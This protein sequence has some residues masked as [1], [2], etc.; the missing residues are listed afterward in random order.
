MHA[1]EFREPGLQDIWLTSGWEVVET[2]LG[3]AIRYHSAS[4]LMDAIALALVRKPTRLSSGEFRW[5]RRHVEL[6]QSE[7]ATI[8]DRDS[9]TVS[10]IERGRLPDALVDREL[11]RAA[12]ERLPEGDRALGSLRELAERTNRIGPVT[13]M[14]GWHDGRWTFSATEH[15]RGAVVVVVGAQDVCGEPFAQLPNPVWAQVRSSDWIESSTSFGTVVQAV[16]R[17]SESPALFE[18]AGWTNIATRRSRS[19]HAIH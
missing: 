10:L 7:L 12:A 11:R 17:E 18:R 14:G 2:E 6:S 1:I 4:E 13:I 3:E 8:L 9:Q 15:P 16:G 5:L 19:R